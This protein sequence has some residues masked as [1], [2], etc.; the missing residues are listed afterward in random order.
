MMLHGAG[1]SG[2][3]MLDIAEE[4]AKA[5]PRVAWIM[6]SAPTRGSMS[7]WFGRVRR[8][9]GTRSNTCIRYEKVERQLLDL[10]ETECLRLQLHAGQ[11]ALWGYSAGSMMAAWLALQLPAPCAGLVLLHGL[12][13]DNRLPQPQPRLSFAG[14]HPAAV[15]KRAQQAAIALPL[16]P[17][18]LLLGGEEDQQIPLEAVRLG[19]DTLRQRWGFQDVTLV[20]TPG[21]DHSIGEAEYVAM[22]EFL[23]EKLGRGEPP[24]AV[25]ADN[26]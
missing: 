11:V 10:L 1:D 25:D 18:A 26:D 20:E 21:Q 16:R 5:M 2:G 15:S 9:D 13:P 4:W 22:E 7:A 14:S 17:P 6:P 24:S 8:P 12:V 23:C 3:G 19:A